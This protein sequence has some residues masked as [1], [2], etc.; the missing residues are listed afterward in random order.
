MARERDTHTHAP[1]DLAGIALRCACVLALVLG[2]WQRVGT[3]PAGAEGNDG[4]QTLSAP[5][6]DVPASAPA[7]EAPAAETSARPAL[8]GW[9]P[10]GDLWRYYDPQ[11]HEPQVG[12]LDLDG[13]RY[14]LAD[15]GVMCVGWRK[16]G[17]T[18]CYFDAN[19]ALHRGWLAW[20][21]AWCYC[22]PQTGALHQG[23]L[24]WG[25]TWYYLDP[26]TGVTHIGWLADRGTWYYLD[27]DGSLHQG[28]L[29]WG[30]TWYYLTPGSGALYQGWLAWG[31][32]WYYLGAG[33]ALH[34]GWLADAGQWYFLDY[35]SGVMAAGGWTPVN[36]TWYP[37]ESDGHWVSWGD[38]LPAADGARMAS[39]TGRQQTLIDACDWTPWPGANLCAGWVSLVFQNA[40]LGA[41]SG[42][43]C[44]VVNAWCWSS[45]L[46]DLQ[47]GMILGVPSHTHTA[48]GSIWGHVAI[49]VGNG[50]VRDSGTF[51]KRICRLGDWL[52]WYSTTYD[53]RWGWANGR[54]LA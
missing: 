28:W 6:A 4:V 18:W 30:D 34:R 47:P 2:A 43:A 20:G 52:A 11:T 10:E 1:S 9:V 23:W 21:G 19:G 13:T 35:G 16:V 29:P 8:S 50:Y 41:V 53:V 49:Y 45:D 17:G 25:G 40:G 24:A 5:A 14:Y 33:G 44:D 54:A 39:L 15:D 46:N 26:K 36:G 38:L 3:L 7:A 27:A 51:G 37:F 22:D 48:A 12:W 32:S 42:D 31:D